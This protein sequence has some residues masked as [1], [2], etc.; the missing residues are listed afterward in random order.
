MMTTLRSIAAACVSRLPQKMP[1][2][3]TP[4]QKKL[5]ARSIFIT[6]WVKCFFKGFAGEDLWTLADKFS[7]GLQKGFH[8]IVIDAHPKRHHDRPCQ[9]IAVPQHFQNSLPLQGGSF[10]FSQQASTRGCR[11]YEL[12]S[13]I[14]TFLDS[15]SSFRVAANSCAAS[16]TRCRLA[17]A[18]IAASN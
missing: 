7:Q 5:E 3:S 2:F 16:T 13:V 1:H 18:A 6:I 11:H 10:T 8:R 12:D 14:S 9:A 15:Y 17:E 4:S